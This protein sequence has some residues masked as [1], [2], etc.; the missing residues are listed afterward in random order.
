MTTVYEVPAD[1]LIK[2]VAEKLKGNEKVKS[3]NW[4]DFVK[5][6]VHKEKAPT[7]KDW[8]YE[9]V[10]AVLRKI[11]IKGPIGVSRLSAEFGGRR[12]RTVKPFKA[13][14]GS[15]A[16]TRL[17]L[18]QLQD[19][20]YVAPFKNKGRVITSAGRSFLDNIA[21]DIIVELAKRYP[22]LSKYY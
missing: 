11:Y 13:R 4:V 8:W 19:L 14:K 16:I 5:T 2:K 12:D 3:P 1:I 10:A 21:H 18:K 9:R 15:G 7:Q 17:S 22:E 6:G 20:G